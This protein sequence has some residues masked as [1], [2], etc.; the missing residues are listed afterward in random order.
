MET[1]AI[2]AL[3]SLLWKPSFGILALGSWLWNPGSGDSL[4]ALWRLWEAPGGT[5]EAPQEA[6]W[7]LWEAGGGSGRLGEASAYKKL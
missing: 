3:E 7:R 2:F 1:W 5:Q 6:L 4:E